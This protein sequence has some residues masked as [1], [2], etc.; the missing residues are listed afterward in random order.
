MV[1]NYEMKDRSRLKRRVEDPGMVAE[2]RERVTCA[3]EIDRIT[4]TICCK[5]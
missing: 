1:L 4:I 5:P 3:K 2:D